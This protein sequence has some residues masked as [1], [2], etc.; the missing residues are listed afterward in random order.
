MLV[1]SWNVSVKCRHHPPHKQNKIWVRS[2]KL[3]DQLENFDTK[4]FF[5]MTPMGLFFY[6]L[7]FLKHLLFSFLDWAERWQM[8]LFLK[9]A[10]DYPVISWFKKMK[11]L[12]KHL[13]IWRAGSV[14][15]C[16]Q[17][18]LF[19]FYSH[20]NP[21]REIISDSPKVG[22]LQALGG[23]EVCSSAGI[24]GSLASEC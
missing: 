6:L 7:I 24:F 23:G 22:E 2:S 8:C 12:G 15:F 18:W 17:T 4:G 21:D 16:Q 3:H 11:L 5:F 1:S 14:R 20:V 10:C 13:Y 19:P 9:E